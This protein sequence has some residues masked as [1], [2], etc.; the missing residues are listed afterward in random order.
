MKRTPIAEGLRRVP[1]P[2]LAP[3]LVAATTAC[4]LGASLSAL[5]APSAVGSS[6]G[7][8][9]S[10]CAPSASASPSTSSHTAPSSTAARSLRLCS[11]AGNRRCTS[12]AH[13]SLRTSRKI[14]RSAG[15]ALNVPLDGAANASPPPSSLPAAATR[16]PSLAALAPDLVRPRGAAPPR[17]V[18]WACRLG[19]CALEEIGPPVPGSTWAAAAAASGPPMIAL[20]ASPPRPPARSPPPPACT[21]TCAP[22]LPAESIVGMWIDLRTWSL[23]SVTGP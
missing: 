23:G 15:T 9:P 16:L 10:H 4:H 18:P 20:A 12:A 17:P 7:H 1:S 2:P 21:C 13:I 8:M 6:M 19:P 5:R 22:L 14:L 3:W 11:A